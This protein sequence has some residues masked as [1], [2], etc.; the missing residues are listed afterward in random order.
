LRALHR[1]C[2]SRWF[3]PE[4]TPPQTPAES[5]TGE[6]QVRRDILSP[7]AVSLDVLS[8][9]L[10]ECKGLGQVNLTGILEVSCPSM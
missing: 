2:C 5:L 4:R 9:A 8:T 10:G 7:T 3:P 1:R 6:L